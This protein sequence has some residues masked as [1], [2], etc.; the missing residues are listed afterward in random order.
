[1]AEWEQSLLR[2]LRAAM[3]QNPSAQKAIGTGR[4]H[5]A[6]MIEPYLLLLLNG[7]KT[8]ESRFCRRKWIPYGMVQQGDTLV[9]KRSSGPVVG[10]CKV[11]EVF[12]YDLSVT[13]LADI[14]KQF[15]TAIAVADEAFWKYQKQAEF[16]SLFRVSHV[17]RLPDI[18]CFKGKGDR[19]AWV[20]LPHSI[21]VGKYAA[22][23]RPAGSRL[24]KTNPS[25]SLAKEQ[26]TE[27]ARQMIRQQFATNPF[28]S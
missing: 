6:V 16:V 9:L 18:P 10:I 8:V 28:P 19:R 17:V 5:L 20:V 3:Q 23:A 21:D 13:P 7:Q 22:D 27:Q 12:Y 26:E 4:L 25:T 2:N 11:A 24:S 1:M 15:G 14:R